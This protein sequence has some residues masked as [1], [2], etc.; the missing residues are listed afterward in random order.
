ME[1]ADAI[2]A[3]AEQ[4]VSIVGGSLGETERDIFYEA[5]DKITAGLRS[6]SEQGLPTDPHE[7]PSGN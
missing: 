1:L 4:A 3:R 6:L 5:F 7:N 2:A